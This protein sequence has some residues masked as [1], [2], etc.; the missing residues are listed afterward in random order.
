M[1]EV[2]IKAGQRAVIGKKVKALRRKGLLPG[3]IYGPGVQSVP[4]Q[5]D[6]HGFERLL[7]KTGSHVIMKMDIDGEKVPR[8]VMLRDIQR[9]P[10]TD[11]LLHAEFYQVQMDHQ[12]RTEIPIVLAGESEAVSKSRGVLLQTLDS[13]EIECLPGDLPSEITADISQIQ[14]AGQSIHVADLKAP[15]GVTILSDADQM[16]AQVQAPAVEAEEERVA[17]AAEKAEAEEKEKE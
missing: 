10:A 5:L 11:D 7:A 9:D 4:V 2:E 1:A 8:L 12:V 16:V 13:V 6:K 3:N 15:P 14:E 17:E